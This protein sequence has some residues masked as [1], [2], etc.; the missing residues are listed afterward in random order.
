MDSGWEVG[1]FIL[2]ILLSGPLLWALGTYLFL[3]VSWLFYVAIMH[4]IQVKDRLHPVAKI[5]AY[6]LAGVGVSLNAVLNVVFA[7]VLFA[8]LPKEFG[9][10]KRMQRYKKGPDGWRK[11]VAIWVCEHALN[12]FDT[13]HC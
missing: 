7:T 4:L 11:K 3:V 5:H 2:K 12:Q 13:G 9:L 10:T 8:D 1:P 6:V